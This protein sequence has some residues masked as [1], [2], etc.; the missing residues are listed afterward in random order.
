MA[1]FLEQNKEFV[2]KLYIKTSDGETRIRRVCL[3]RIADKYGTSV[4]YEELVGLV[5]VFTFPEEDSSTRD[6]KK[7][8]VSLT[9]YDD[10]KDLITVGSTEELMD[11]IELFAG[12]KFMRITTCVK[13]KKSCHGSPTSA[14][15]AN[16]S[17]GA[18]PSSP[19]RGG[20]DV[21]HLPPPPVRMILET[22]SGILAKAAHE[23]PEMATHFQPGSSH[24]SNKKTQTPSSSA[25]KEAEPFVDE[26]NGTP[27]SSS[28]KRPPVPSFSS[29]TRKPPPT[30]CSAFDRK[31]PPK[32][33]RKKVREDNKG[34]KVSKGARGSKAPPSRDSA[35][36]TPET[37][38]S[39]EGASSKRA[40]PHSKNGG[41]C[42]SPGT[43]KEPSPKAGAE[44]P[45]IH[46][47]H[48]CDG[49][50]TTPIV[51]NRYRAT[52]LPD[53][54]LCQHCYHNYKGSEI[55][56]KPMELRRDVAFQ[57]RW[58]HR[59][60][61]NVTAMK[62][63]NR[64][65]H[66]RSRGKDRCGAHECTNPGSERSPT[67]LPVSNDCDTG[68]I[69][70]E[71]NSES[72]VDAAAGFDDFDTLLK[73]A[74][75][76]SLDDVVQ[77]SFS[78]KSEE[79][80]ELEKETAEFS[81]EECALGDQSRKGSSLV[82]GEISPSLEMVEL[83]TTISKDEHTACTAN[84]V[85]R[86]PSKDTED[87]SI[88]KYQ[89][90]KNESS[91]AKGDIPLFLDTVESKTSDCVDTACDVENK[92]EGENVEKTPKK[93]E[94]ERGKEES[95]AKC[96]SSNE[97]NSFAKGDIPRSVEIIEQ[98]TTGK[99]NPP[100]DESTLDNSSEVEKA[101]IVK[102]MER[103]MDATSVDSEKLLAETRGND[104][105]P[106]PVAK[107]SKNKHSES[108]FS[109]RSLRDESFASDAVGIG[110]VAEMVGKTL[111]MVAGEISE[112]LCDDDEGSVFDGDESA[113]SSKCTNDETERGELILNPGD[114]T[115]EEK[116]D[117]DDWSVVKSVGTNGT[118]ESQRIGQATQMLGSAL[119][120]SDIQTSEENASSTMASG[121]SFSVPSSVPTDLGTVH[122][123]VSRPRHA[124]RW[125][126]ELEKLRELGFD[127]EEKCIRILE[128]LD[129]LSD[130]KLKSIE[131]TELIG[132]VVSE[133][134][135][136]E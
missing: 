91:N 20:S 90:S 97:E 89:G 113:T 76:R 49:C 1:S 7:Y 19:D 69:R 129:G 103:A 107:T 128:R 99:E 111:D 63:R 98:D 52:N 88:C 26:T 30:S 93:E 77:N 124:T 134:L 32:S 64:R 18:S 25:P 81:K 33:S 3:P 94:C 65:R 70:D 2:L 31:P 11:A 131:T 86:K 106:S 74:I 87:E 133:I 44:K 22:F 24:R 54:D 51:G 5:L 84:I 101:N 121:S 56:F 60:E 6:T 35:I 55:K 102:T 53:Y 68:V 61:M 79:S 123:S 96:Q 16:V 130:T 104:A 116:A 135:E 8:L 28:T 115:T 62:R 136:E 39:K 78:G 83:K 108:P 126:G 95:A 42:G 82:K 117:E 40:S 21:K 36:S 9:Y 13:P 73:E 75:R 15:S 118:T 47:R 132:M 92:V 109:K 66:S 120:N 105:S 125:A 10:E 119:F 41:R 34:T 122:S 127:N 50:L 14:S 45:F 57:A 4:S 46:G 114:E 72:P 58:H 59:Y 67:S 112:M 80:S 71:T 85:S 38:A 27:P 23:L 48:T 37:N 29:S 17:D 12:Q 43:T 100:C 110:D